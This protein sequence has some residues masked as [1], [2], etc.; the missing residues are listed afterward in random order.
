MK[1]TQFSKF[2]T[3]GTVGALFVWHLLAFATFATFAF[4]TNPEDS[5]CGTR[6]ANQSNSSDQSAYLVVNLDFDHGGVNDFDI[7]EAT[8]HSG[9]DVDNKLAFNYTG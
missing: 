1:S 9:V 7:C 3:P 8:D 2:R 4:Y 6:F 5:D